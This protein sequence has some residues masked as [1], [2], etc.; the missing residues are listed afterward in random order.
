MHRPIVQSGSIPKRYIWPTLQAR[1]HQVLET[2]EVQVCL[3]GLGE[4]ASMSAAKFESF[5]ATER[6]KYQ[7][8][9]TELAIQSD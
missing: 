3:L 7:D 4:P 1:I 8:F 2:P 5:V 6:K 9:L